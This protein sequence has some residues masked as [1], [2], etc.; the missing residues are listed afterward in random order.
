M[1]TALTVQASLGICPWLCVE[2]LP[3]EEVWT[4]TYSSA[5]GTFGNSNAFGKGGLLCPR[6]AAALII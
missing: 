2:A 3:C 5:F 6:I 1:E 4:A